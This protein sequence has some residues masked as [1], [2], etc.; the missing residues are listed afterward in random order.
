[1]EA[2]EQGTKSLPPWA[3]MGVLAGG[4]Y[5]T[6]QYNLPISPHPGDGKVCIIWHTGGQKGLHGGGGM[7]SKI[8]SLN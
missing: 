4:G 6:M 2:Y 3:F 1:M 5:T 8:I 7:A